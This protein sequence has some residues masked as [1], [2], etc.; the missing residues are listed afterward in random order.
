MRSWC[1]RLAAHEPLAYVIGHQPFG[2]LPNPLLCRRPILVPRTETEHWVHWLAERLRADA[3]WRPHFAA[4][5]ASIAAAAAGRASSADQARQ[6]APPSRRRRILDLCSGTGCIA[7]SL[8]HQMPCGV[9]VLAIDINARA[10]ELGERNRERVPHLPSLAPFAD[11]LRRHDVEFDR[12]YLSLT[13]VVEKM[14]SL[15][16]GSDGESF[17]P[18]STPTLADVLPAWRE[19]SAAA[20]AHAPSTVTFAQCDITNGTMLDIGAGSIDLIVSNP[21][22]IDPALYAALD[23]SVRCHEDKRAL[24]AD[25]RGM[26]LIRR[27]LELARVLLLPLQRGKSAESSG[28]LDAVPR[29]CVEFGGDDQVGDVRRL[30]AEVASDFGERGGDNDADAGGTMHHDQYERPRWFTIE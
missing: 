2:A 17:A 19:A 10:V 9:D 6:S 4:H 21:P 22:Y 26:A 12:M 29:V 30:L 8:A 3:Q 23:A 24:I 25:D 15:R 27:V 5:R 7:L 28:Q 11:A 14:T 18:F 20:S 1:A 16:G 13:R